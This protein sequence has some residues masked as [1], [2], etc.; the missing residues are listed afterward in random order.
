M[1]KSKRFG[2]LSLGLW[3]ILIAA[4]IIAKRI[5]GHPDWMMMFHLPAAVMLVMSFGILSKDIR[6]KYHEQLRTMNRKR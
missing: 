5:Y 4:G 6:K 3:A 1:L 2:W